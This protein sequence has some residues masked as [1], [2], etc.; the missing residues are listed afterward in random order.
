MP[1]KGFFFSLD[2]KETKDQGLKLMVDKFVKAF[3]MATQV[4][5]EESGRTRCLGL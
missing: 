1:P 5:D 4:P 2:R 3:K